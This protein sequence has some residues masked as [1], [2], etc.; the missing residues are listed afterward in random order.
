MAETIKR[1]GAVEVSS[2]NSAT[3]LYQC[4]TDTYAAISSINVCNTSG[5]SATFK[6][7]HVDGRINEVVEEDYIAYDSVI[8]GNDWYFLKIPKTN[9]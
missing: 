3:T 6:I 4:P 8:A 1:L 7:A 9:I 2:A 5:T